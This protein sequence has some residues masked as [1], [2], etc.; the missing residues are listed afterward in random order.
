MYRSVNNKQRR[1]S[2]NGNYAQAR[3]K[4]IVASKIPDTFKKI[5]I[6]LTVDSRKNRA[7]DGSQEPYNRTLKPPALPKIEAAVREA[8]FRQNQ[9]QARVWTRIKTLKTFSNTD[10]RS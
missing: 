4:K 5:C 2:C 7:V 6:A 8:K 9:T 3:R 10:I 1:T